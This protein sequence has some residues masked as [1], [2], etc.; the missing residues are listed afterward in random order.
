MYYTISQISC[1]VTMCGPRKNLY[2]PHGRSLEIPR[3][4][5]VLKAK[6]LEAMYENK[7]EFP[8]GEGGAK[9]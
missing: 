4:W 8:G 5:A 2:Q 6:Y 1:G 3:G 9:Q 7:M